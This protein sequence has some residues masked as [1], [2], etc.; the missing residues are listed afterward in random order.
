ML[1]S[2]PVN[3]IA[4][5]KVFRPPFMGGSGGSGGAIAIYTKRGDDTRTSSGGLTSNKVIGYTQIREFYSPNYD[6]VDSRNQ[7]AD[8]RT[9]LYWNPDI[10]ITPGKPS[11]KL[12]FYNN[13]V[14]NAFRVVIEGVSKNGML[15]RFE[16]I[17]E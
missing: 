17:M 12:N 3:D 14:T 5:I 11:I 4:Y 16:Q 7:D 9:T 1:N 15:T 13:D 8:V 2:V 10:I 6:R